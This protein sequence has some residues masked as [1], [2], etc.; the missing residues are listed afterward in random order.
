MAALS[1]E[2]TDWETLYMLKA[3]IVHLHKTFRRNCANSMKSPIP[4]I[5]GEHKLGISTV[6]T[7]DTVHWSDNKLR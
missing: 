1:G 3:Y 7:V 5:I 6:G 4:S 2:L